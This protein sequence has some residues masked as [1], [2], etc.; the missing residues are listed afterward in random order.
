MQD[1]NAQT[2]AG[3][4]KFK[5][6]ECSGEIFRILSQNRIKVRSLLASG[7]SPVNIPVRVY[8]SLFRCRLAFSSGFA[9]GASLCLGI[10]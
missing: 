8:P 1:G 3:G 7:A 9:S 2:Y 6:A 5:A 10:D 4:A